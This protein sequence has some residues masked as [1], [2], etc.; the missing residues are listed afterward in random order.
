MLQQCPCLIVAARRGHNSDVHSLHLVDLRVINF[1]ED[2]LIV[3][4]QRVIAASIKRLGRHSAKIAHTRQNNVDQPIEKLVHPIPAQRDH[5]ANRHP[6]ADFES[7]NRLFRARDH[8]LLPGN[9]PQF[10]DRGIEHLG[11]LRRFAYTH[12]DHDLVQ[13]RNRHGILEV[14][15]LHQRRSDFLA[16]A[17]FESWALFRAVP[18]TPGR[19]LFDGRRL[20]TF[21]ALLLFWFFFSH[22]SDYL[23][24]RFRVAARSLRYRFV[25]T[26]HYLSSVVPHF[27]QT[28]TLRSPRISC[29]MRTGPHVG[30][31]SCTFESAIRLSCS[32]IPPFTL[33][34][35]FGRTC[36][37]T[38][39]TCST[40]TFASP[41]NTRR[42]RPSL[43][44]SRPVITFTVSLRRISTLLCSALT[45]A[46]ALCAIANPCP[47]FESSTLKL[48]YN[49]S[50]A[51]DTI[52]RNFRS[53]NSRA[54][55]PNTRVPTGSPASL[56]STAAF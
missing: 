25:S 36:F 43:P 12:V 24:S 23:L 20:L 13:V 53:R 31:T 3:Q 49:T 22:F 27:L 38:I 47:V 28:L 42:T 17:L 32:A 40:R 8:R 9:L 44:L 18:R 15:F 30:Q 4:A 2:Q 51:S 26:T 48:L 14:E 16:E 33:R 7:R 35:G 1:R 19:L 52:F 6:L 37:F 10:V 21:F 55:G 5:G 56:I 39:I 34:C 11:V 29:P 46:V 41:G 54:T 50:G 45:C